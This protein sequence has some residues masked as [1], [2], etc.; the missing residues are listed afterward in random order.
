[1]RRVEHVMGF[2]V[3]LR[4]DDTVVPEGTGDAVFA[5]LREVDERFSPFEDGSEVSRHGRGELTADELSADLVEV[6]GICE[7]YRVATGG[8]FD[9]RLPGRSLDPCA[10]VKG[11]SVQRAADLLDRAGIRRFCLNAGGDVVVSGGP[12]RIGVRHPEAADRLCAV[13]D[14]T[15]G[16]VATSARYERGDHILD[17]RTGRPVTGLDSL[18]VVAPTLTEADTVATAAFALGAEGVE[19]AAAQHGCEVFAVLPGGRVLRTDGFP[20]TGPAAA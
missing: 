1:M 11:W 15:E 16:A 14:L 7:R 3:S 5:W 4:I 20:T 17:G 6:L 9:V 13:L 2:P 12:W 19:W 18:T 10:V 8:A